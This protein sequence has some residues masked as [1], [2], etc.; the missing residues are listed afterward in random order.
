V[1]G[2]P[3]PNFVARGFFTAGLRFPGRTGCALL[4]TTRVAGDAP[5]IG[6]S[7]LAID[8]GGG[9]E[10]AAAAPDAG[11]CAPS[12]AMIPKNAEVLNP[13]ATTLPAAAGCPRFFCARRST[14]RDPAARRA[15]SR[16]RRPSRSGFASDAIES[17]AL[18]KEGYRPIRP[19]K[20]SG[21]REKRAIPYQPVALR[22]N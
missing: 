3:A 16:A 15:A 5:T 11:A 9:A 22:A 13:A 19:P 2:V 14:G 8:D 17:P 10:A 21:A 4:T 7:V 1:P 18:L 6:G 20:W 12:V